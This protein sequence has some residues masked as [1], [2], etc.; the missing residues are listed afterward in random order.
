M[1]DTPALPTIEA[2]RLRLRRLEDRD[3]D[4]LYEIF[5]DPAVMRFWSSLPLDGRP[6]AAE[7]LAE[8]HD[9]FRRKELFQWGVALREDD[10]VVGT[11]TLCRLDPGNRR[12]EVGFA[13]RR[14]AWGRGLMGEAL[15]A[16]FD[17]AFGELALRRIEADV[18]P[19][20]EASIR[21]LERLGFEREGLARERWQ[22][23]GEIQDACYYGLL[24][25]DWRVR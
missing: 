8:I 19:R 25:R 11:C 2:E 16:L 24:A 18:D 13:L 23:G 12:A 3:V 22:V 21:L 20:N 7:L 17:F 6:A 1:I 15:T 10:R 9:V 5:S 14:D 4:A